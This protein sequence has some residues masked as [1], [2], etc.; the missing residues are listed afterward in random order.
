MT[1]EMIERAR[2]CSILFEV[3]RRCI[4]GL[5]WC[6]TGAGKELIGPCPVCG[7]SDRFAVHLR[8]QVLTAVGAASAATS[9]RSCSGSITLAFA[10]CNRWTAT[11]CKMDNCLGGKVD[12]RR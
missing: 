9:S 12:V 1:T 7:G 11:G 4:E 5:R 8:N 10:G 3:L 2:A 6:G